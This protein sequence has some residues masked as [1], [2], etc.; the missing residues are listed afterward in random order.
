P[1]GSSNHWNHRA[2]D[3]SDVNLST[4]NNYTYY[5]DYYYTDSTGTQQ[6]PFNLRKQSPTT[7]Y[8]CAT[9][10]GYI[11]DFVD[12]WCH[13]KDSSHY[14]ADG[15]FLDNAF[16]GSPND[17]E[18]SAYYGTGTPYQWY[19]RICN[20]MKTNHNVSYIVL[21]AGGPPPEWWF[22]HTTTDPVFDLI[23][24]GEETYLGSGKHANYPPHYGYPDPSTGT[25]KTLPTWITNS[26]QTY[27]VYFADILKNAGG[28]SSSDTSAWY[29]A[30][31]SNGIAF[32]FIATDSGGNFGT[33]PTNMSTQNSD[34]AGT[35]CSTIL[36]P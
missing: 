31:C 24:V 36:I 19:T 34:A 28:I 33:V 26:P 3:S 13:A 32:G 23:T 16:V 17:T 1:Y 35:S 9:M 5:Y 4:S 30:C 12:L 20:D 14:G 25:Y 22:T 18:T 2:Y 8:Q 21:N 27:A 6:G 15:I 29:S 11:K 10:N 7:G